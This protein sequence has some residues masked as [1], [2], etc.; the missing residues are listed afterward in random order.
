M[1]VT[2]KS[3]MHGDIANVQKRML[4][5]EQAIAQAQVLPVIDQL[6]TRGAVEYA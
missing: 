1:A 2:G 6:D 3:Q 5:H 4:E